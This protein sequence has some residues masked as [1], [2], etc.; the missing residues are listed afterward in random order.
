MVSGIFSWGRAGLLSLAAASLVPSIFAQTVTYQAEDA[1]LTG[2]NVATASAGF[3][4]M[5]YSD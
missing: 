3:S 1:T 2:V 4:G 5:R